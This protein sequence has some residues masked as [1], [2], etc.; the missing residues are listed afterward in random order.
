MI[1]MTAMQTILRQHWGQKKELW[2]WKNQKDMVSCLQTSGEVQE[3]LHFSKETNFCRTRTRILR[4][5]KASVKERL[6]MW[7][8]VK[9]C[10]WKVCSS[11]SSCIIKKK[12]I[13][14]APLFRV[15]LQ[16]EK[17]KEKKQRQIR[18]S[19]KQR[20]S[21]QNSKPNNKYTES[22]GSWEFGE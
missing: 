10:P 21:G 7:C 18:G 14:Y 5:N 16:K 20:H 6:M 13:E 3:T 1:K 12:A 2:T 15:F 4:R 8:H 22:K 11:T 17:K 19:R 9:T